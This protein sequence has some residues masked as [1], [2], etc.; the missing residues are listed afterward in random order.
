[1]SH[2]RLKSQHGTGQKNHMWLKSTTQRARKNTG[3]TSQTWQDYNA[4]WTETI[5]GKKESLE[6]NFRP[7]LLRARTARGN[8]VCWGWWTR[9]EEEKQPRTY[10]ARMRCA[11][12]KFGSC[13][14]LLRARKRYVCEAWR[15]VHKTQPAVECEGS[16]HGTGKRLTRDATASYLHMQGSRGCAQGW[17]EFTWGIVVD[18]HQTPQAG[19]RDLESAPLC[20]REQEIHVLSTAEAAVERNGSRRSDLDPWGASIVSA[21]GGCLVCTLG[22]P[23]VRDML[24]SSPWCVGIK[25]SSPRCG[26]RQRMLRVRARAMLGRLCEDIQ[27]GVPTFI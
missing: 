25:S 9:R 10:S 19:Q 22:L 16:R 18:F 15:I 3:W 23:Q 8:S 27:D 20:A 2:R 24:A 5:V 14:L 6:I 21:V 17:F 4:A 12:A 13:M 7:S 11:V 1:M 26:L